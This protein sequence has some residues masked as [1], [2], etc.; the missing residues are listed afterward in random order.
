M[1]RIRPDL[2]VAVLLLAAHTAAVWGHTGVFWGD[3]GRWSHEVERLA[4]G[5]LPYRDFQWHYPP[6]GLFV[7]GLAARI[8]GT[9]RTPLSIITTALAA[10]LVVAS[11]FLSRR[12]LG[13]HDTALSA[14][15]LILSCSF[16]PTVGAALPRGLYSPAA[17]V[18]A[19]CTA[20][21]AVNFLRSLSNAP[22]NSVAWMALFCALG[23]L[24]KQDFWVPAAYMVGTTVVRSRR[25]TAAW[26]SG[27]VTLA[28][29]AGIIAIAGVDILLPLL[30]GFG[31]ATL[32][33]GQGFPSWE[34][35]TI[36]ILTLALVGGTVFAL[37]S[38]AKRQLLVKPLLVCGAVAVLAAGI[39]VTA[40]MQ[41][42]LP[43][44]GELSSPTQNNL[45]YQ[46]KRDSPLLRPAIG[47]MRERVSRTPIPVS[48]APLLLL[49]VA[50]RWRRLPTPRRE[51]IALT[52][53][54]AVALRFRRAFE[55]T[56]WFEFVLALPILL[57]AV[58]LLLAFDEAELRRWRTASVAVLG[59][60]A[61]WA[62][63][64]L[65][66]GPGTGRHFAEV[67][68]TLR[69]PMHWRAGEAH[70]YAVVLAAVDSLDASRTRPL[71]AFGFTGGFNYFLK[72]PNPFPITQ[73]FYFS[74]F[75][76]DSLVE[77]R[78][79]GLLLIDNHVFKGG[80]FGAAT[81]ALG[82]WEQPRVPAPYDF[83]DRPRFERL[84]TGCSPVPLQGSMFD[85]YSCP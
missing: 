13:R 72:R 67:T 33:G 74:A 10:M 20:I 85:L 48:L 37:A 11:V 84:R 60:L 24:S 51:F 16:A 78:P 41:T 12:A 29:V 6:F 55:G 58:E 14:I 59:V 50:L 68:S 47:W 56:E 27:G 81:F 53:G 40:S 42:T 3:I 5:E 1:R 4:L 79:P 52:L 36:D 83:Y 57:A 38:L 31:H 54:L 77:H 25:L 64:A 17:I 26:I 43:A 76:A 66:R 28:G 80:S 32:A 82:Q 21:A 18:G 7:E 44:P 49:A 34:R 45:S 22:G 46:L 39:H 62:Y 73:D 15:A 8:I 30:G 9:D 70:D 63:A 23:V 69:G 75:N 19:V 35:I 2:V 61:I 71:V 65:G